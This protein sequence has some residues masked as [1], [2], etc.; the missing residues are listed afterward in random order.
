MI[1]RFFLAALAALVVLPATPRAQVIERAKV[2]GVYTVECR[3][4]AGNLKWSE[5]IDNVVTTV[6]KN[7]ALDTYL[8]GSG[9]TATGPFMGLISDSGFTA[10]AA[11]DTMSSHAGWVEAGNAN[12]PTYTSPRPT[13]SWSSASSGSKGVSSPV[14]F[15]IT[16][17]GNIIG[18]FV[19]YGS[20]AV[21]TID[22]TS[23]T[24]YSAGTFGGGARSVVSG[25]TVSVTYT[26]SL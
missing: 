2:S 13:P 15:A 4:A 24:L 20:G 25:D 19:V 14:S 17:T 21:S 11:A 6:G 12:T 16:G 26:A 22:N 3:D 5:R 10:V 18:A 9:Y 8:T 7:L 23:G 1:R